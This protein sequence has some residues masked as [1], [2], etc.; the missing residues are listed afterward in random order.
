MCGALVHV[1]SGIALLL[2]L[3]QLVSRFHNSNTQVSAIP[4]WSFMKD[5]KQTGE[6]RL[7]QTVSSY[8]VDSEEEGRR[9][10]RGRGTM[11]Q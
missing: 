3:V 11:S 2:Q 5:K 7:F 9:K 1:S 8:A 6:M 4:R 10:S